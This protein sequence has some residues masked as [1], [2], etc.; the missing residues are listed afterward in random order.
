MDFQHF[1]NSHHYEFLASRIK[2]V[3]QNLPKTTIFCTE[4]STYLVSKIVSKI[5]GK[6]TPN[7]PT[8]DGESLKKASRDKNAKKCVDFGSF[9][10]KR[11]PKAPKRRPRGPK[12]VP[13]GPL[14][15]FFFGP[16]RPQGPTRIYEHRSPGP[17]WAPQALPDHFWGRF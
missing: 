17:P 12:G 4:F 13:K 10:R 15:A 3:I 16:K 11:S 1:Q 2:N 8:I 6:S 14:L 5:D 9:P 7:R